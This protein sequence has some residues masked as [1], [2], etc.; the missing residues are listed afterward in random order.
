MSQPKRTC[1]SGSES[2]R[3]G[4]GGS[5]TNSGWVAVGGSPLLQ[6]G[7]RRFSVAEKV[8]LLSIGLYRLRK[9]GPMI[10]TFR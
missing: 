1:R 3:D 7:E 5:V 10:G 6:Q 9:K 2:R 4:W 8:A